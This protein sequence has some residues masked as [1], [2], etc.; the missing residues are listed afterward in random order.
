MMRL[1][2]Q[3]IPN[4]ILIPGLAHREG[5]IPI[6]P[7]KLRIKRFTNP[8]RR[9]AFVRRGKIRHRNDRRK[10]TI[11]MHMIAYPPP[12]PA[13]LT[14]YS[15]VRRGDTHAIGPAIPSQSWAPAVPSTRQNERA[16]KETTSTSPTSAGPPGLN[17][18]SREMLPGPHSPG[19]HTSRPFGPN[20]N[21]ARPLGR[22]PTHDHASFQIPSPP[23]GP[24]HSVARAVRPRNTDSRTPDEA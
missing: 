7:S 21:S 1:L 8:P 9:I 4:H 18:F 2:I 11:N 16:C 19:H 23:E 5:R 14:A 17:E 15:R 22:E 12:L 24:K 20:A 10:R 13:A 6:L 3:N